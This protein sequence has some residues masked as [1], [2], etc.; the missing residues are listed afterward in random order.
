MEEPGSIHGLR[1]VEGENG[2]AAGVK[3][4]QRDGESPG[5]LSSQI[6]VSAAWI[7]EFPVTQRTLDEVRS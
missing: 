7:F 5:E 2:G 6:L 4:Q 1:A 3:Q